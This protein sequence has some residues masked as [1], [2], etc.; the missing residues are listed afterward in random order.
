MLMDFYGI[1]AC[2]DRPAFHVINQVI[3]PQQLD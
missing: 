2:I 3:R 1:A